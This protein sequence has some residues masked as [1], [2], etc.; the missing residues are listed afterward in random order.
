MTS[1]PTKVDVV[2]TE[3][4]VEQFMNDLRKNS[5]KRLAVHSESESGLCVDTGVFS[6]N[7]LNFFTL[8]RVTTVK[9]FIIIF[10][11]YLI[12]ILFYRYL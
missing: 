7:F 6:S 10:C 12:V 3:E 5:Q 11:C 4:E 8:S 9:A 2:A 1:E